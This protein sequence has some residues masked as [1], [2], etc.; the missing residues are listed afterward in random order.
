MTARYNR[1]NISIS[2]EDEGGTVWSIPDIN[3]PTWIGEKFRNWLAAGNE[4]EPY[5][6]PLPPPVTVVTP[7]QARLALHAAGMLETVE[8]AIAA[9]DKPTQV[10]WEYAIEF[11]RD[12]PLI[13]SLGTQLGLTPQQID[14]FFATASQ[15]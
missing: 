6:A 5:E 2:W 10:T 12:D 13:N 11:R 4:I 7:R 1:D 9:S 15:L 8:A 3:S 14:Q